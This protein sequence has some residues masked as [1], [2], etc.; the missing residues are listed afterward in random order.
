MADD[1]RFDGLLMN[2]AQQL[3]SIDPLLD[4]FFGFLNRKT[5]FFSGA[6]DDKMPEKV[7]MK[8]FR[9][10]WEAG[11]LKRDAEKEKYRKADEERKRRADEQLKKDKAEYE[12]KQAAKQKIV[13]VP[14]DTP[15]GKIEEVPE[16]T[17][18]GVVEEK[19]DEVRKADND[20]TK[21]DDDEDDG[22]PPPP[23]NGGVLDN[24]SWTQTLSTVEI[25]VPI[26]PGTKSK[27]V[28]C[29]IGVKSIKVGV[30]GSELIIDGKFPQ[31]V[32]PDDCMWTLVDNKMVSISL[33][34]H[35]GM[36]WWNCAV[37][38]DATINTRKIVPE[39]SKLSDLDGE[40][41]QTVEK[42]MFDQRAKAA[43]MPTSDQQKQHDMLEKF[44]A[45]HPEMDFSKAKINY[46][47]NDSGFDFGGMGMPGMK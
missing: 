32:K 46:G 9:K 4:V 16:D 39:N 11:Q 33:E 44:K 27:Q 41:R 22:T 38:G 26:P 19:T 34:K 8:Y 18:V 23:G 37:E 14:A 5:D 45:A 20:V 12:A 36:N 15:A 13:E 3:G 47:G 40:T 30:K 6:Q 2:V 29:D 24:Y 35:D 42:M 43:G 7:V 25:Q 17:P 21:A 31:K 10:H 1:E 28:T